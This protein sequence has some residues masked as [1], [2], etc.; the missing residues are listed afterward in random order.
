MGKV[1]RDVLKQQLGLTVAPTDMQPESISRAHPNAAQQQMTARYANSFHAQA[2]AKE[3]LLEFG[4]A[5]TLPR[6]AMQGDP[7]REPVDN[8]EFHVNDRVVLD[9][10]TAKR[11]ALSLGEIIRQYEKPF[12]ELSLKAADRVHK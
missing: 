9:Y 2:T 4:R 5:I 12:S 10:Y 8:I 1:Q 3:V 6:P 7:R 11:L